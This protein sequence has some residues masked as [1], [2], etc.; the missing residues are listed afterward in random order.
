[1]G[2]PVQGPSPRQCLPGGGRRPARAHGVR[3]RK[4]RRQRLRDD[5]YNAA[6]GSRRW[7]R[8][9]PGSGSALAVSPVTGTV[10][11]TGSTDRMAMGLDYATIAYHG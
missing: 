4:R 11:V 5:P 6:A 9:Y 7:V 8:L 2:E 1:V 3:H 10:F